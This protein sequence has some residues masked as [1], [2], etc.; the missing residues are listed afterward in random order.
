MTNPQLIFL[1][2]NKSSKKKTKAW[3]RTKKVRIRSYRL[4]AVASKS[5]MMASLL[6]KK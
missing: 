1:G 2:C 3:M 5:K 4:K 6:N